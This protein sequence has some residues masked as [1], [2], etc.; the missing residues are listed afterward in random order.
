[1]ALRS[2]VLKKSLPSTEGYRGKGTYFWRRNPYVAEYTN[3]LAISWY[4]TAKAP[5]HYSKDTD[6]RCA[7][8]SAKIEVAEDQFV[9]LTE[10]EINDQLVA[11]Y[12]QHPEI[13]KDKIKATEL[14]DNFIKRVE[15]KVSSQI[16]VIAV[17]VPTPKPCKL[18][19]KQS[20]G[21]PLCYVVKATN[22]IEIVSIDKLTEAELDLWQTH[23]ASD[24]H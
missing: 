15:E 20:V 14:Y 2:L 11:F 3:D 24:R 23:H 22:C 9:D 12:Y 17:T 5:G 18:C 7:I 10:P 16:A 19:P 8:I 6:G 13:Y 1:M 21:M 4:L